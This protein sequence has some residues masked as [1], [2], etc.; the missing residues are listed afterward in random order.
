ML[1]PEIQQH[2]NTHVPEIDQWTERRP[3]G[4]QINFNYYFPEINQT[5]IFKI[6][7]TALSK[8]SLLKLLDIMEEMG[9]SITLAASV[10]DSLQ[11]TMDFLK[12]LPT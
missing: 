10:I 1:S 5:F 3:N 12:S 9:A 4:Y 6:N 2:L 8:E 7:T 11:R